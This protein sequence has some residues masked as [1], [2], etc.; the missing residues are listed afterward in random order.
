MINLEKINWYNLPKEA[1]EVFESLI[2]Q[3]NDLKDRVETLENA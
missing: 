1:K 3:I 2:A